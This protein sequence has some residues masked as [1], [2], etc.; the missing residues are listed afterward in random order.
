MVLEDLSFCLVRQEEHQYGIKRTETSSDVE[1]SSVTS[2]SKGQVLVHGRSDNGAKA[3]ESYAQSST[4]GADD[5]WVDF[6]SIY[7][8]NKETDSGEE[9][10]SNKTDLQQCLE[11]SRKVT[12]DARAREAEDAQEYDY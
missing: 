10:A 7:V 11:F 4:H 1:E 8:N 6:C 5:C 9:F 3:S 2:C 12:G